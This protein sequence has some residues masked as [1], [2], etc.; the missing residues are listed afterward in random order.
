MRGP[1]VLLVLTLEGYHFWPFRLRP[2][3]HLYSIGIYLCLTFQLHNQY[4][5]DV[6]WK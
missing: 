6:E 1:T 3:H 4:H 2:Q 5:I